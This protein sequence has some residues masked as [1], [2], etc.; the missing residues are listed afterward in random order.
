[1]TAE[2]QDSLRSAAIVAIENYTGQSFEPFEGVV[3]I[4]SAGG[5]LLPLPRRLE[6][7][8]TISQGGVVL[9][10]VTGVRFN[11]DRSVLYLRPNN[12]GYY[13]QALY[14][15]SGGAYP[16]K[17]DRALVEIDGLW[18]WS[19]VPA[20]VIVALRAD[21]E[22]QALADSNAMSATVG[23]ARRL[24]LRQMSQGNLSFSLGGGGGGAGGGITLS[25]RVQSVLAPY[26]WGGI[27]R[28]V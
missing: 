10:D 9:D 18:G 7:F 19:T 20:A 24:G 21:M 27:G 6:T 4:E 17:W 1:M 13:E 26:V 11:Q 28:M 2:Q 12:L 23:V 16:T 5:P 25:S 15:V 22:E 8:E 14:E 3:T